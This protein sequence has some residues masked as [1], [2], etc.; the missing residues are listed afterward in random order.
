M[1]ILVTGS[2]GQLGNEIRVLSCNYPQYNFNFTDVDELDITNK[3]AVEHFFSID[4]IDLVI[5][6]AAYTAVDKAESEIESAM[7]VNAKAVEI[8]S[9]VSEKNGAFLIHI[10]TDYVFDGKGKSPYKETDEVNPTSV[11]GNSKLEGEKAM[12]RIS[13]KGIIIRTSWLYSSFG[14]NFVKTIK[15]VGKERGQLKVVDDQTGSPTYAADLAKA[16][17]DI[18]PQIKGVDKV[19][20]FHF[21]NEGIIT[22]FDFAKAIIESSDINCV[23]DPVTSAEF[24]TP[25]KRPAYSVLDNSKIKNRFG[26]DIPNWKDSLK[27]CLAKL[28]SE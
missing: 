10:S 8:L 25:V 20:L 24:P 27:I 3:V 22:W 15:R 28:A 1:N 14:N 26:V 18:I 2:K 17:L 19:E 16:I 4:K 13:A 21:S 23:V 9:E 7:L 12:Q 11:Y 5:N 6:A